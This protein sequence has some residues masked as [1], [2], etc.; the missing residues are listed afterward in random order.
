MKKSKKL[1]NDFRDKLNQLGK[2]IDNVYDENYSLIC[3][4]CG[5]IIENKE[6]VVLQRGDIYHLKCM[7]AVYENEVDGHML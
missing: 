5:E 4:Q 3:I 6:N 2:T 1:D 7:S